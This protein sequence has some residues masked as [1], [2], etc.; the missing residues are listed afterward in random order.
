MNLII[1]IG[2]PASGK[3]T[4]YNQNLKNNY[5]FFDDF[6]SNFING[7]LIN[8]INKKNNNICIADPRLCNNQIFIKFMNILEQYINKSNIKL[9]LFENNKYKCF[10]NANK[11]NNKNVINTIEFLS[12]IY[13]FNNYNKYN[14]EILEIIN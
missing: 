6:I 8:E 2:L 13:D 4:F 7:N 5:L 1:L 11:R 10:I 9:Y 12:N 3:T 14:Y